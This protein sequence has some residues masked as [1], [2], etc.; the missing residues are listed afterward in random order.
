[1]FRARNRHAERPGRRAVDPDVPG[2]DGRG[3]AAGLAV[4]H[5]ADRV[6]TTRRR[7]R[8]RADGAVLL[9]GP[10]LLIGDA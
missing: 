4:R 6:T 2:V 5:D 7:R 8:R 10:S 9:S 3:V 1:M